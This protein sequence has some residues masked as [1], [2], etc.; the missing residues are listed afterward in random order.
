[1]ALILMLV[2]YAAIYKT[3]QPLFIAQNNQI[4]HCNSLAGYN[5]DVGVSQRNHEAQQVTCFPTHLEES[6]SN[7]ARR[8]SGKEDLT[9]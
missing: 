8:S 7:R 6:E 9:G 3:F 2:M 1:M 4:N 5:T